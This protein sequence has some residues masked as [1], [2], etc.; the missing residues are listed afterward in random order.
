[1]GGGGRTGILISGFYGFGNI[2]DEAVLAGMARS[3]RARL[4]G[5]PLTVLSGDREATV[6]THGVEAVGRTDVAAVVRAMRRARLFISGGGSLLQD[7]TSA[8]SAFYYLGVLRLAVSLVPRSMIYAAGIGP[9]R[10]LA[11]R[12]LARTVLG[13]LDAVTVRDADSAALVRALV[14]RAVPLLSADPAVVL[15]AAPDDRADRILAR[16]GIA[17]QP[18]LGVAV[19]PWG[20]DAF[21]NPLAGALSRAAARLGARIVILPFHPGLDLPISRDLAAACGGVVVEDPLTPEEALA[22]VAR[23]QVLV[24]LRLHALL[25]AAVAG[26]PPVGL[27]Y[28]PKVTAL[29]RELGVEEALPL[30][31]GAGALA[32]AIERAWVSRAA[33]APRLSGGIEALRGRAGLAADEAAR[34]Y[35]AG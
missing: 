15:E 16:L 34:L 12:A 35:A 18:L 10:R 14:P 1:M 11:I 9:L 30:G 25:L 3:L 17:G 28:D 29:F 2:G 22:L 4:G 27:V 23:M 33:S 26:T 5:V 21:L 13:R 7:V 20:G 6:A 24:G 8:R 19:R 32:E 31:A